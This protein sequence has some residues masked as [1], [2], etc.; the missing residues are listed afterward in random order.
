[1]SD[2]AVK[3]LDAVKCMYSCVYLLHCSER[4]AEPFSGCIQLAI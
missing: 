1:M 4:L 2:E 3:V